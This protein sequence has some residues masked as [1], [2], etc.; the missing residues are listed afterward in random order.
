MNAERKSL[1]RRSRS[2][3]PCPMVRAGH[4]SKRRKAKMAAAVRINT[5]RVSA[6]GQ[7]KRP[8]VSDFNMECST[9]G[10]GYF[11]PKKVPPPTPDGR[12]GRLFPPEQFLKLWC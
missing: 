9:F 6:T 11:V 8:D 12:E 7:E 2:S 4:V 1:P 10:I 3:V 5:T